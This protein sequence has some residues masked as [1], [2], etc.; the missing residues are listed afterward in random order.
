[1]R[2]HLTFLILLTTAVVS[3]AQDMMPLLRKVR[4]RIDKVNDYVAEGK[5]KTDVVFI[6]VPLGKVKVYF[7]KPN[8]FRLKKDGGIS[9][10]P[11]GGVSVN[12]SGI[13]N[14]NDVTALD[15]GETTLSGSKVRIVKLLPIS[16]ESEIVLS[17]LYIDE[18]K[19]LVRKAVTT[20][21]EN[22]TFEVTMAY[23]QY[24]EYALPDKVVFSFNTREY[25]IPK[26]ITLEFEDGEKATGNDKLKNKKGRVEL[27]YE[28]YTIN[29]GLSDSVFK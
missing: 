10:L 24:A 14:P 2:I 12:M 20:T 8:R 23:G 4:A 15:A 27:T 26:G 28:R 16:D 11:K 9:V 1:M 13:V 3:Q 17:T 19:L 18:E 21:R 7:K 22:G 6:K 25:K 29:Q 5:M